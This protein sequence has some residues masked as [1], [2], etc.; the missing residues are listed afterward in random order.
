MLEHHLFP[1]CHLGIGTD[2]SPGCF[3]IGLALERLV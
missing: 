2:A 1:G 3:Q